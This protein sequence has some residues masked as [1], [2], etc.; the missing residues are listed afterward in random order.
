MILQ[1][2]RHRRPPCNKALY[3][4]IYPDPFKTASIW[5]L[6]Y[7]VCIN[8][9]LVFNFYMFRTAI[10]SPVNP[11]QLVSHLAAIAVNPQTPVAAPPSKPFWLPAT[12][13]LAVWREGQH[14]KKKRTITLKEVNI[15]FFAVLPVS[16]THLDVYKR[17][18]LQSFRN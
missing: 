9:T 8:N 12:S 17:Q 18:G 16:Y 13:G 4:F 2:N 5:R 11:L 1:Q 10:T 7:Y 3:I 14:A 6:Y 15:H